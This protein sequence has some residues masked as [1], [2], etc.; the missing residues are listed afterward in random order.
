ELGRCSTSTPLVIDKPTFMD[1]LFYMY[2]S[3]TTG[4]PKAAIVKH[5]R[6]IIGA[7]GVHNLNALRPEDVI[8]TSLPLYH[9]AGGIAALGRNLSVLAISRTPPR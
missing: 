3:G 8:Y 2:T 7:L 6:Y 4:L 9:T 5:A 1:E